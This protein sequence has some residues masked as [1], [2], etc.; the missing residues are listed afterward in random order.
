MHPHRG[1]AGGG[2]LQP[3]LQLD[4]LS[5]LAIADQPFHYRLHPKSPQ[6]VHIAMA[7]RAPMV[8]FS[9]PAA[10]APPVRACP[11]RSYVLRVAHV[12]PGMYARTRPLFV[13]TCPLAASPLPVRGWQPCHRSMLQR[14][15]CGSCP[16]LMAKR[17]FSP[18]VPGLS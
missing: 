6:F 8:G 10:P 2:A 7:S 13:S 14:V 1:F 16:L 9:T 18:S 17:V 5:N 15:S 11:D 12:L 4:R 3:L